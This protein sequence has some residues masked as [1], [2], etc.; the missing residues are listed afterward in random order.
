MSSP[1]KP[2][3]RA[4]PALSGE[5]ILSEAGGKGEPLCTFPR[6][7][8][9]P[10]G[11]DRLLV[12]LDGAMRFSPG[13]VMGPLTRAAAREAACCPQNNHSGGRQPQAAE[14]GLPLGRVLCR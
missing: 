10:S 11:W 14:V 1:T 5:F 8:V 13:E 7:P 3:T 9:R 12:P 4:S 2:F 6:E